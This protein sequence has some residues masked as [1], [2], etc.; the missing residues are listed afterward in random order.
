VLE[1][2]SHAH[3]ALY[4]GRMV[5]TIGDVSAFSL[6]SAKSMA[7]GEGGIMATNDRRIYERAAIF[8]HYERYAEIT[9]SDLVDGA[10]LPWGGYKY[11]MHQL[12]S[13]VARI[14][15][16]NY[17][18][19]MAD[20]DAAM[21]YFWDQLEGLPGIKPHRPAKGSG[22]TMGGWY[23][24]LG[25][26]YPEK[27]GG[28]SITRF[29]QAVAAEGAPTGAGCNKALHLH[30]LFNTV[31]V[32]N[33]GRPTRLAN[34]PPGVDIR[35]AP[36]SLPVSEGLQARVFQ[37]PWFKHFQTEIIKEYAAAFRKVAENYGDLLAGD[38]GNPPE[39]GAWGLSR[40][41]R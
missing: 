15:L 19:Q 40:Q 6:M 36:G 11:R 39:S 12:T 30:P 38:T 10:G 31:D 13:A 7:T 1:D 27:M 16:K 29:C 17:P 8:G 20:I 33:A 24:P 2:V 5:G 34:L 37:V 22:L 21:N 14:Q 28:L 18:T 25:L 26:Y 9:E 3:G 4:K 41:R 32:Y 23:F 35:Q